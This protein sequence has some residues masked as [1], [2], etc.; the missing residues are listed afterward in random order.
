L[1]SESRRLRST[2]CNIIPSALLFVY[3]CA[4]IALR[5]HFSRFLISA[6]PVF[7]FKNRI[8]PLYMNCTCSSAQSR[9]DSIL[10]FTTLRNSSVIL[11]S[12]NRSSSLHH[13]YLKR[14][15]RS[16]VALAAHKPSSSVLRLS[17]PRPRTPSNRST[18]DQWLRSGSRRT[19]FGLGDVMGVLSK[20]VNPL[21]RWSV[22]MMGLPIL[23]EHFAHPPLFPRTVLPKPSDHYR[24]QR[25]NWRK[26]G[27]K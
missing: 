14:M 10:S 23:N 9:F 27:K 13:L 26:C 22:E 4:C 16:A 12:H 7:D 8:S 1:P 5:S 24:M 18:S 11:G 25:D 21:P 17:T 3:S 2:H 19:F 20:Y 15:K 6:S